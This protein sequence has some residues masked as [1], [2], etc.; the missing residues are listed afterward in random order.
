[1]RARALVAIVLLLLP[2]ALSAQRIPFGGIFGRRPRPAELPPQPTAIARELAYKRLPLSIESYPLVSHVVTSGFSG[3][4]LASSWTSVGAGTRADYRLTRFLSATLDI[5][6]SMFG[7]P[8]DMGTAELGTRLRPELSTRRAY[9]FVDARVGYIYA[10]HSFFRPGA[11]TFGEFS[12]APFGYG[13]RY[14][15]GIGAVGGA[16]IE[17]MLTRRFSLTTALSVMRN[18]MTAHD[19]QGSGPTRDSYSMT[20]Y[21]S[22]IG[23]KYNPV[24]ILH[25]AAAKQR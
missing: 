18:H 22:S 17:F 23:L 16:G 13:S 6:S 12:P 14:S 4:D 15:Q 20:V 19:F 2:A 3:G 25:E 9:P 21:R 10:Y 11:S 8:V 5:T 1:M 24:R 7:G